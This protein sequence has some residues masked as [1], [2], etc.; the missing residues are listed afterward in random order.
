MKKRKIFNYIIA[1]G[2]INTSAII[3][4]Q[5]LN[6]VLD[7]SQLARILIDLRY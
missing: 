4:N 5:Y 3:S 2:F 1:N 6:R 7:F